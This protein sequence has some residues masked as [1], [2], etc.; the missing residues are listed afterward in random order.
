MKEV[1]SYNRVMFLIQ[2]LLDRSKVFAPHPPINLGNDDVVRN[3]IRP[4]YDEEDGLPSSNPPKWEDYRD[5]AN[6]KIRPGTYVWCNEREDRRKV[7]N[8]FGSWE[9][10]P[11]STQRPTICEVHS[12]SRDRK[13][14]KFKFSLGDRIKERW[15]LDKTRPVPNKPGWFYRKLVEDN[16][17]EKFGWQTVEMQNCFNV[18]AYQP[19]DYKPFLCDAH[20]KGEYLKWAP[21]L[22]SAEDWHLE[23]MRSVD[24]AKVKTKESA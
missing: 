5:A 24:T 4:N 13:K 21:Q 17:G 9:K 22:L 1:F 7:Y 16:F 23:R 10:D 20:L 8:R 15:E 18:E 3:W 12:V 14:V 6:A 2:G 19:G 11:N